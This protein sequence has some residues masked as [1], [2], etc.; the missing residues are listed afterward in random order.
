[1][2]TGLTEVKCPRPT[3][4]TISTVSSVAEISPRCGTW[5]F[6]WLVHLSGTSYTFTENQI[7]FLLFEV[8]IIGMSIFQ[9]PLKMKFW[10]LKPICFGSSLQHIAQFSII[11][12]ENSL[13]VAGWKRAAERFPNS[14]QLSTAL[15]GRSFNNLTKCHYSHHP[16]TGLSDSLQMRRSHLNFL[17]L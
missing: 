8:K 9:I 11:L 2:F 4:N 6:K 15:S 10:A 14:S 7:C 1:M 13:P 12:Q 3:T 16:N 17:L 5:I